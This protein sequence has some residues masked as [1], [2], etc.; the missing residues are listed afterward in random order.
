MAHASG[1]EG[2]LSIE[3]AEIAAVGPSEDLSFGDL[4][5]T[6]VE[7][8]E[9]LSDLYRWELTLEHSDPTSAVVIDPDTFV[10]A[11][12]NLDLFDGTGELVRRVQ[13]IVSLSRAH[14]DGGARAAGGAARSALK[15]LLHLSPRAFQLGLMTTQ[16][17]FLDMSVL[18]IITDKIDRLRLGYVELRTTGVYPKREFVVQYKESDLAFV[19]RLAEHVGL[20]FHFE[21]GEDTEKMV[22]SD[23][24]AAMPERLSESVI[25]GPREEHRGVHELTTTGR[26]IPA[27]YAVQDYN[28]RNPRLDL[29]VDHEVEQGVGGLIEYGT[30]HRSP[31]EGQQLA[32]A[33]AQEHLAHSRVHEGKSVVGWFEPGVRF[34]LAQS[35]YP[36]EGDL[37]VSRVE[38]HF[39]LARF[40]HEKAKAG[41]ENAFTAVSAARP[42]RPPRT[43]P[44]PRIDGVLTA[45]VQADAASPEGEAQLDDEGRYLVQFH[46]DTTDRDGLRASRRVRMAQPFAGPSQGMHFPLI[47]DTEVLIAFVDGDPDRP[48]IV[49]AV[50]NAVTPN[51]VTAADSHMHRIRSRRGLVV[52]FGKTSRSSR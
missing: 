11:E 37:V 3:R 14:A 35:P 29:G 30:H 17:I 52:E 26:L 34:R 6:K 23:H 32:T 15:Y 50:P 5:V 2:S 22:F 12:V 42:Y 27:V 25:F 13:G 7:A 44:K 21:S 48:I 46:F 47:P 4:V 1:G 40:G 38:H 49:G 9:A 45:V 51:R 31:E 10:G 36:E 43:T 19:R 39:E 8:H 41:Y 18:E 24:A 16:E 33:R 28:Y 20:T